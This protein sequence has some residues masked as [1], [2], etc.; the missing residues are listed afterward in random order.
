MKK[1][2]MGQPRLK[3]AIMHWFILNTTYL[4]SRHIYLCLQPQP[5]THSKPESF[6]LAQTVSKMRFFTQSLIKIEGQEGTS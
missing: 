5:A 4:S 2:K 3:N 1:G 6:K